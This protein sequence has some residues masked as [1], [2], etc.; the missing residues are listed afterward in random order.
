MS[1]HKSVFVTALVALM[2]AA[3]LVGMYLLHMKAYLIV[4]GMMGLYGYLCA[5]CAF[6]RWLLKEPPLL[7]P[8]HHEAKED[9]GKHGSELW[10]PDDNWTE[11]YD[12]IKAELESEDTPK[13]QAS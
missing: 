9:T 3:I 7:P 5:A 2:L 8:P 13:E 12:R 6:C 1:K 11:D 4:V 10:P